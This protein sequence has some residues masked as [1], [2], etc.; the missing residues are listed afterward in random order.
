MYGRNNLVRIILQGLTI[1][2]KKGPMKKTQKKRRKSLKDALIDWFTKPI[3][4]K[5]ILT[6]KAPVK[7]K[8]KAKNKAKKTVHSKSTAKL[9]E[10]VKAESL[11]RAEAEKRLKAEIKA[12]EKAEAILK[13]ES[14][15]RQVPQ[16][17]A[18]EVKVEEEVEAEE[19][20]RS[21]AKEIKD[22]IELINKSSDGTAVK[23]NKEN[24]QADM[25]NIDSKASKK[26]GNYKAA[27][28]KEVDKGTK[29]IGQGASPAEM[30]KLVAKAEENISK[31]V[32]KAKANDDKKAKRAK[33]KS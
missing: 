5:S 12:R 17:Q 33:R 3:E 30:V 21:C 25:Y 8:D 11:A 31:A 7:A 13:A 23:P 18:K 19:K 15:K 28:S 4:V 1:P 27:G 22:C 20:F 2:S 29:S 32:I 10:K 6:T 26:A 16:A 14:K 24:E 9:K